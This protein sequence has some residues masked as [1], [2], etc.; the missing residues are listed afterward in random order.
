VKNKNKKGEAMKKIVMRG[1]L[2]SF[3][4][5]IVG[6]LI[7][8]LVPLG[9]M[10]QLGESFEQSC[11]DCTY[12]NGELTCQCR[13]QDGA[14]NKTSLYNIQPGGLD[15]GNFNG[16]LKEVLAA[17][18]GTYTQTCTDCN[19][20]WNGS[21]AQLQ[22]TCTKSDQK[23]QQAT[24]LTNPIS[25]IGVYNDNGTL[26]QATGS[27]PNQNLP[28]PPGSYQQTCFPNTSCTYTWNGEKAVLQCSACLT[29]SQSVRSTSI[30]NPVFNVDIENDNGSLKQPVS[31]SSKPWYDMLA[32]NIEKVADKII[33]A[34]DAQYPTLLLNAVSGG[35]P[36]GGEE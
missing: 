33:Q 21:Q 10:A 27:Q 6:A 35:G 34:I 29:G 25:G 31:S 2:L 12:T 13:K 32:S 24:T 11:G 20:I 14:A 4:L 16:S 26:K 30:T 22:C 9:V 19:Y 15:I 8:P 17:P 5:G 7:V 18:Q 3:T 1:R 28:L 36:G 23:T